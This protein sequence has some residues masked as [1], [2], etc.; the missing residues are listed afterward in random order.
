[1]WR[2][3]FIV[4]VFAI[5]M[6]CWK[7]PYVTLFE[8]EYAFHFWITKEQCYL[9]STLI[10]GV[11]PGYC[12]VPKHW[13]MVTTCFDF[14]HHVCISSSAWLIDFCYWVLQWR[15]LGVDHRVSCFVFYTS[16]FSTPSLITSSL[17]NWVSVL[18]VWYS[19]LFQSCVRDFQR[20]L[21][22]KQWNRTE[23]R[24]S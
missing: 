20:S 2:R 1:M 22:Q 24:V 5:L 12:Q 9:A 10:P 16:G 21:F 11:A 19:F 14:F 18:K 15:Q 7:R 8:H 3:S 23:I 4:N 6:C 13:Q 17:Y